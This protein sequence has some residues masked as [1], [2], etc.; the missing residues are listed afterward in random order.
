MNWH[1]LKSFAFGSLV[2]VVAL[3]LVVGCSS[4]TKTETK[5]EASPAVE[6]DTV[7][8]EAAKPVDAPE[9]SFEPPVFEASAEKLLASRLPIERTTEGWVRL[10]DGHTLFGWVIGGKA[11]WRV[12]DQAIVADDGE[13][14]LLATS[15]VWSDYELELQFQCDDET[16]SGVFVRTTLDPQSVQTDCYEV[17]IAPAS[18]PFPTG[19]IVQRDKGKLF[20]TDADTW[21]TMNI[22]CD[23]PMLTVTIDGEVTCELD[24][25]DT[26]LSGFIGLQHRKGRVAFKDI[27][28]RPLGLQN[29]LADGLDRWTIREGMDGEYRIND[30]GQLVVDGGKQ[31]LESKDQFGD[32][33]MLADYKMDDPKSNSGLFFRAIPGD[34]MM[35]YE[36]QVSNETIDGN[37]LQPADCGAGGIFRRQDARVVAGEPKR[38]NS[39]LLVAEGN[40]FATWVNG[41][42][43]TDVVDTRDADENPRR[44]LRLEPGTIIV[45]GHDKTTQATYRQISIASSGNDVNASDDR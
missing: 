28:I 6:T 24:D 21:H 27:Q 15:T 8:V 32:F 31:Q 43:V 20:E 35:G 2:G 33:V 10:F 37:P 22:L 9:P 25:A 38:W 7:V 26:P 40:H 19:G 4:S 36:C 1:P 30:E 11:N 34:E 39:I 41:V 17:N 29:L 18:N 44:G 5:D 45:Q 16:N 13:N 12:E 3:A 14:C 23:G 42:Q